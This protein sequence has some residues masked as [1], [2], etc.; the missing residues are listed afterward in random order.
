[1]KNGG[2]IPAVYDTRILYVPIGCGNCLECRKQK[3]RE[4]QVRLLEDIKTNRNGKFITLTFSNQSIKHICDTYTE[5]GSAKGYTRDN[6]IA[7]KA[8]RLFLERWRKNYKKSLRHWLVTELGH[9]GTENI[10]LHGIIWTDED[11]NNLEKYWQ[12]GYIWKGQMMNEQLVNYVNQRTVNY[13]VKYINK[14]DLEHSQYKSKILT[15]A[16]IGQN[17]TTTLA[18]TLNKWN[19]EATRETYKTNTG[20]K[21]AMPTYWRNKIYDDE[22]RESLWLQ[23]LDK[24]ERWVGGI[25]VDIK[26][27]LEEYWRLLKWKREQNKKLGYGDYNK[28]WD[29]AKYEEDRREMMH[30]KRIKIQAPSAG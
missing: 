26:Y 3:A 24:D 15:T 6:A 2:I 18:A 19:G 25:K 8:T 17:Y 29:K 16:G 23:K 1:M 5:I 28:D 11:T 7:T 22:E 4:W 20:H 9:E 12:Y 30:G 21:I 27:G 10:H 13:V 14:Q